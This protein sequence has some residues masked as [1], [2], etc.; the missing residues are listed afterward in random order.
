MV[1]ARYMFYRTIGIKINKGNYRRLFIRE[2]YFIN[3]YGKNNKT[4]I[5]LYKFNGFVNKRT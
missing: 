2:S 1:Y 4:L 3:M 5:E